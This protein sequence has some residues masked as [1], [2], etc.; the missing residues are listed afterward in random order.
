MAVLWGIAAVSVFWAG[1]GYGQVL[2]GDFEAEGAAAWETFGAN[3]SVQRLAPPGWTRYGSEF[4]SR[5]YRQLRIYLRIQRG[6]GTV[7]FDEVSVGRL[8]LENAGFEQAEGDDIARW[9]QDNV[10]ETVFADNAGAADGAHCVRLEQPTSRVSRIWQDFEC[11]PN[12][13]YE[14]SVW[15]RTAGFSGDAYA[16]I[17]GLTDGELGEIVW[18][19]EHV[20]GATDPRLGQRVLEL[21]AADDGRGGVEQQLEL[22]PNRNLL[23]SA[24]LCVPRLPDGSVRIDLSSGGE[25]LAELVAEGPTAGWE[26]RQAWLQSPASG[27]ATARITIEG[28]DALA[29][30]DN[31][32]V[33]EPTEGL[34]AM[35][36][37]FLGADRNGKLANVLYVSLPGTQYG[38]LAKG[39]GI[40]S[41]TLSEATEGQV[42]AVEGKDDP[43]LDL[44]VVRPEEG[45][46]LAWP[47]TESYVLLCSS[48]GVR[49]TAPT[50]QGAFNGLMAVPELLDRTPRGEWQLLA[51][52]LEDAPQLP[53]RGTY[54]AGLPRERAERIVWCERFA[55]LRLNAVVFE[56][57]IWW[58]LDKEENRE[59]AV[60]AF[61][62][63]RSYGLEPI[64]EL[65]SFGWAHIVL[66]REPMV[67]E[68]TWV[69]RERLVLRG[70][71]PV[72]LAHPNVLRTAATD[73]KIERPPNIVYEEGRDYEVIDGQTRHVYRPDAEPYKIKRLPGSRIADGATVYAS[74]DYVSRVNS[75]N[76]PYCPS[77]PLVAEIMVRA[78][79]NTVACLSPK[80]VHIGHDEPAQMNTDSRC[81][82]R[83][84]NGRRITNAELFAEDVNR[85]DAAAKEIDPDVRLMMWADAVN[86]YHNGLQF[87]TDP[88]ADALPLLPKDV[89]LNVW[90]YGP[91]QPLRQGAESLRYFGGRGFAT[92]GSPWY[93]D[94]CAERWARACLASRLRG[95]ECRGVLYTSWGGHWEALEACANSAWRLPAA[96]AAEQ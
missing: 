1:A 27:K 82:T 2:N 88:T 46:A 61:D 75:H 95:E 31:V 21:R 51:A 6:T 92:T 59:V 7:W 73:I 89:I 13:T 42:T 81:R 39:V 63:F 41:R 74:Y 17:Y 60:Q 29:Y 84:V 66:A 15:I 37:Q 71:E 91:D 52:K 23:L 34:A 77:E 35:G 24:D 80:Y 10:G 69:Q 20:R 18:T 54:M 30:V 33:G 72:A 43:R 48:S 68:G 5:G 87:P 53:F 26:R 38:L 25:P 40:L 55:A 45:T 50:E 19:S 44:A 32:A 83:L 70:E 67:A 96:E 94:L 90:F 28:R 62:D 64:P 8:R 93:N 78:I 58:D 3:V 47:A 56:D 57:D 85:L 79:R 4:D 76:C 12:T 36:V 14:A 9:E 86:P 11:E 22:E 16:E 65:Q 49:I